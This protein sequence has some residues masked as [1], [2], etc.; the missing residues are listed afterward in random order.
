MLIIPYIIKDLFL[1]PNNILIF[2]LISKIL[3][4]PGIIKNCWWLDGFLDIFWLW[5][6]SGFVAVSSHMMDHLTKEDKSRFSV[7][8]NIFW[9]SILLLHSSYLQR[10]G[11][12]WCINAN[13]KMA[14]LWMNRIWKKKCW[15]EVN[16]NN[17]QRSAATFWLLFCEMHMRSCQLAKSRKMLSEMAMNVSE[18]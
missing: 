7:E 12:F 9:S 14:Q 8:A 10:K 6:R 17:F 2:I 1:V 11:A 5:K 4:L 3:N 18:L 15:H 16:I 13:Y